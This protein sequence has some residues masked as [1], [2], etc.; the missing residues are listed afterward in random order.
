MFLTTSGSS[1][2]ANV[3]SSPGMTRKNCPGTI[4]YEKLLPSGSHTR[5][6]ALP[7]D[8]T[9]SS[10]KV[11]PCG[12]SVVS[13]RSCTAC[14]TYSGKE[15]GIISRPNTVFIGIPPVIFSFKT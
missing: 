2:S 15:N 11:C 8:T 3:C 4:L 12:T 5:C 10:A 9:V 6:T 7:R 1:P 13:R 14:M